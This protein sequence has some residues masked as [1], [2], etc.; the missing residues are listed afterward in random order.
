MTLRSGHNDHL[1]TYLDAACGYKAEV[2]RSSRSA[3]LIL[4]SKSSIYVY[5]PLQR[6]VILCSTESEYVALDEAGKITNGLQVVLEELETV[7]YK[8]WVF[9]G[10][11]GCIAWAKEGIAKHVFSPQKVVEWR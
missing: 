2:S 1:R 4:F 5:S 3:L 10:N 8:M 6:C 11:T 9:L 7:K